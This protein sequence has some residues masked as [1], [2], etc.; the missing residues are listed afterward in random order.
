[1][2]D[3]IAQIAIFATLLFSHIWFFGGSG[4]NQN[5]TFDLT[6]S[7]VER[8]RLDIDP[9]ASNTADVSFHDG[10]VYAN[11]AP[12]LAFAAAVPYAVFHAIHGAPRNALE[13]NLALYLCTLAVCGV[14]GALVGV[15]LYRAARHRGA[16][17]AL[18]HSIALVAG[19]G[20]PLFAYSTML[21]AHVP[22]ALLVLAAFLM[23]DGTL[24]RRPLAAGAALGAATCI[25][26]LCAPLALLLFVLARGKRDVL[27]LVLGGLPFAAALGA[28]QLAA[29]G[30]PFRTSL[31]TM[32]PAFVEQ[33]AMLGV[34]HA[35]RLDALWGI[36]LSPFRG[37]FFLSPVL[38]F[39]LYGL[40]ADRRRVQAAAFVM[41][42]VLN[43]SFNGW[44][45]GYTVGPRYLLPAV[46]L[47]AIALVPAA[48]RWRELFSAAAAL[49]ILFNVAVT[50][51]D[52][53]PPDRLRAPVGHYALPALLTGGAFDDEQTP[54]LAAFYTGHTSTNRV[55]AD[56]LLPFKKHAPGSKESEWASFNLGELLFGPG[57]FA[58][59]LPWLAVTAALW[60]TT[61][62][63][64]RRSSAASPASAATTGNPSAAARSRTSA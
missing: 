64:L 46:P 15:L 11:K 36:T 24:T 53:Q 6:R 40:I 1:V 45:G 48:K 22:S 56:E 55:A 38:L 9:Y 42:L 61:R 17:P 52:P 13:L 20:T 51:V 63:Y 21:F 4:F 54:W 25:N 44:H 34:F 26:Y 10:H 14:S 32:N 30:S 50:A 39:A 57:S 58:S 16:S 28:Y 19:F 41:L 7:L 47:L 62:A 5:A 2:H 23:L 27:R 31:A 49:S 3:R 37:L 18:A 12:G 33:G 59:L 60:L 8:Q 43:A 35:P 29:F